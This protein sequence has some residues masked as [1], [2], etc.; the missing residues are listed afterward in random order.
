M[1]SSIKKKS[2]QIYKQ[3]NIALKGTYISPATGKS[4]TLNKEHGVFTTTDGN[5]SFHLIANDIPDL[6]VGSEFMHKTEIEQTRTRLENLWKKAESYNIKQSQDLEIVS[7]REEFKFRW[8]SWKM[9]LWRFIKHSLR[10]RSWTQADSMNI[11]RS[12]TDVYPNAVRQNAKIIKDGSLHSTSLIHFKKLSL[13]PLFQLIRKHQISSVL[14]FGCGWGGNTILLKQTIPDL[15][16]WSFDYSPYR[17]LSTQFNLRQLG[18]TPYRL[19][20]ADGSKLPLPDNSV[21]LVFTSHVLEQMKQV[22]TPALREI[23]RVT[24][25]FAVHIEP[26]FHYA[27]WL[28]RLRI[29]RKDYP[30][31]I[32]QRSQMLDW[33]LQEYRPANPTWAPTPA[34]WIVLEKNIT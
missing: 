14:D 24:R 31:D 27:D 23:H 16:V 29:I 7:R 4:L 32:V 10:S 17:V 21:D 5:E 18:L 25:R 30:R 15:D 11:Y 3:D 19:F 1:C 12:V 2:R 28:H 6:R 33:R 22:L 34:E 8:Q 26:T 20:V 13:I 9:E